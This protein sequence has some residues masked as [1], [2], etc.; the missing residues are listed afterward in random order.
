[1]HAVG[2]SIRLPVDSSCNTSTRFRMA[3]IIVLVFLRGKLTPEI[4]RMKCSMCVLC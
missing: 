2:G 3:A 4:S 1:M